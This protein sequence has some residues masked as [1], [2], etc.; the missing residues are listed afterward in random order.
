[1]KYLNEK[2]QQYLSLSDEERI[3][4][5]KSEKWIGYPRCHEILSKMNELITYPT[6]NRMPNMLLV[7]ETNNGKTMIVK[8]F[9]NQNKPYISEDKDGIKYPVLS[10]Q[11]PPIPDEKRFY[12]IILDKIGAPFKINDR[13][14]K[15][16]LQVIHYLKNLEVKLLIIDEIH[17]VL[18]GNLSKQRAF[19]NVIKYMANELEISIVCVGT[20]DAFNAIQTDQQLANRFEPFTLPKWEYNKDLLRLLVSFESM[21][22]LKKQS[23]LQE[24][25]IALKILTLSEGTIGE[26][27]NILQN[28]AIK[29]IETGDEKISIE[30]LNNLKW[31]QPSERRTYRF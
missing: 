21:L 11:A 2:T 18:A 6:R 8:R 4:I 5:I 13:A 3:T 29:A 15:K 12:N 23:K 16:Q 25:S 7:G 27:A 9:C 14:E 20:K 10:I 19:L 22:P 17:H 1:M 28:A 24:Q 26:I 31:T 30:I